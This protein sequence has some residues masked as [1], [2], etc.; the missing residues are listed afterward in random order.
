MRKVIINLNLGFRAREVSRKRSTTPLGRKKNLSVSC[1]LNCSSF[2]S[3]FNR[4]LSQAARP[5]DGYSRKR[6]PTPSGREKSLLVPSYLTKKI[7]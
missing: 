7:M 2:N 3:G 6:S 5:R 4:E 1:K